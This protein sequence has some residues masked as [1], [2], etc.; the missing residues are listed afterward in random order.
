MPFLGRPKYPPLSDTELA[1][2]ILIPFIGIRPL[3]G[4]MREV[5]MRLPHKPERFV[6]RCRGHLVTLLER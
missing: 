3:P 6:I 4:T 1:S 5:A 2:Q